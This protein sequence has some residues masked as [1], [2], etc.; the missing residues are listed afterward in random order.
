MLKA[1]IAEGTSY[2]VFR[3]LLLSLD[4]A[5]I[6]LDMSTAKP[7]DKLKIYSRNTIVIFINDKKEAHCLNL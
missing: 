7:D 4:V 5:F 3:K 1:T 6:T 2:D